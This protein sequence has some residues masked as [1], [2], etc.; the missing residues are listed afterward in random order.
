M[1]E[2]VANMDMVT[3]TK[4]FRDFIPAL[5]EQV[6]HII[7]ADTGTLEIDDSMEYWVVKKGKES[8]LIPFNEI[9]EYED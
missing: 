2:M 4:I 3:R 8:K 9:H 1:D 7:I 5:R 6:P